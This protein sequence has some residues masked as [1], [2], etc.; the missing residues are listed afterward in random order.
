MSC[1]K[2]VAAFRS[3][4]PNS[5]GKYPVF[6]HRPTVDYKCVQIPCGKCDGCKLDK[7]RDWAMRCVHEASL[8]DDNCFITLTFDDKYLRADKSLHK[9]DFQKFM[10]RLRK[11]VGKV[12]FYHCGE[13]GDKLERPHHHACL[14]GYNFPDK[15]L[16]TIRDNV[17]LYRSEILSELW[18]FGYSTIG[19]VTFESAAYVARYCM[20]KINGDKADAYYA[21]RVPEYTT[22]SRRP[23][24]GLDWLKKF[25]ADVYPDDKVV[26]RGDVLC[27]P[28]KYYDDKYSEI[29]LTKEKFIDRLKLLRKKKAEGNPHNT[30]ARLA[31]RESIKRQRVAQ[32]RRSYENVSV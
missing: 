16:W 12:R 15:V 21:G 28:P 3:R 22:M 9:P 27:K 29:D 31:V 8:Y 11:R 17:K 30:Y 32:L 13:Y 19:D 24:I 7:A 1:Y 20:K 26:V 25:H 4:E 2:P 5:E 14:F 23:G 10:K 18:P 6:W